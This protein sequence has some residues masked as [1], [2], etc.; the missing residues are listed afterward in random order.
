MA[1]QDSEWQNLSIP[2]Q[3]NHKLWKAR[4]AAYESLIKQFQLAEDE[5][6]PVFKDWNYNHQW[7][8]KAVTDSNAVAHEKGVQLVSIYVRLAGRAGSKCRS[9][10]LTPLV[11]KSLALNARK[12]TREAA[13]ECILGWTVFE[14]D[15]D[16]AENI[17]SAVLEG[18]NSKQPKVVAG[19]VSGLNALVSAF[20]VKVLNIKPILKSLSTIFAHPDK[21][22]RAEGTLLVQTLY[23]FLGPA[24]EPSLTDLKPVQVKELHDTFATMD[25]EGKGKGTGLPTRETAAQKQRR[26]EKE[27]QAALQDEQPQDESGQDDAA[28]NADPP[29][30]LPEDIDPYDLADPVAVLDQLPSGFFEHL[31]SSKWKER[32]EE[33]L[34]PLLA[35]LKP[36][37]KIKPDHYDELVKALAGRMADANILCVIGAANCLECLAKGLR[38]QF[39]KYRSLMVV[40]MLEKFKERKANVVEALSNCLDAMALTVELG[41]L[42]EDIV[43]F[44]KHKNP[45]V[46][47]QTMKF[48]VRCL[49]N[50]VHAIP[51]AEVKSLSDVLLSGLE[52]AVVPVREISAEGLGTL[53]K[54]VGKASFLPI[55]QGQDDLRKVKV[56]EYYEKAEVKYQPPKA[57]PKSQP[58]KPIFKAPPTK[59]K[60]AQKPPTRVD[61]LASPTSIDDFSSSAAS[62]P[63]VVKAAP[64]PVKKVPPAAAAPL[65]IKKTVTAV[66]SGKSSGKVIE[67]IR[68][69][70]SQEEAEARAPDCL[71]ASFIEG[72]GNSLWK[73]R[74]AALEELLAWIPEHADEIEAEV[75][76]RY[77]NKKPG[78]KESNFQVWQRVFAVF[79]LLAEQ[80]PSFTKACMAL[81][82]PSCMEK[83]GDAKIKEAAGNALLTFAEKTSLGFVL[84]HAFDPI[85]KQKA[86]KI[87]AESFLFIDSAL[88]DFGIV[89]VPVRDL[90]ECLKTGLKSV[91]AAVRT[92]ATKALVTT[93][94]CLGADIS[95][96]LQDLNPQLLSTIEGEFAKNAAERPPEP[97]R[98]SAD[99][100]HT[101]SDVANGP[102]GK[103]K[104]LGGGDPLDDLF[105]RVDLDRLVAS[106]TVKACDD[107]AWKVRKEALES[108]QGILEQN[109]RLKPNLGS[110]LLS[111]LKLRL[112]DVNKVVQGLALDVISRIATG[113][114]K[115]FER[116]AKTLASAI[117]S[118]LADKNVGARNNALTTLSN[119]ADSCGLDCLIS[120]VGSSLEVAKPELRSS[121]LNWIVQRFSDLE[122]IKG[123]DLTS[124]ASP[125]VSCLEDRNGEVRKGAMALLPTII[126]SVGIDLILDQTISLK[127]ASRNNLV[128]I[129]ESFRA[130]ASSKPIPSKALPSKTGTKSASLANKPPPRAPSVAS[131]H[132]PSTPS[133][134]ERS[135]LS[136]SKL[137]GLRKPIASKLG[138]APNI[139]TSPA[140][141]AAPTSELPFRSGDP[142][143]KAAR[144]SKETGPLKWVIEGAVRKDQIEQLYMQ[145]APQISSELLGQ[146]FSKDH[147]CEKDFLA[148]LNAIEAWTSDPSSAS[149]EADLEES[150]IRDRLLANSDLVFK[151]LTIRLHDTNTTITMKCLDIIEQYIVALQLDEYRLT[152]YEAS[153]LLPSLIGRCGDSKEVLRTRIRM[154]FKNICGIYPFS[155]VFQSLVDNGLKSKNA[156][157]RAE[158][159]EELS[160]LFQRH[161]LSVCQPAKALPLIASLISDRDSSVRNGALS[162]LASAYASAGDVIL[163]YVGN[164]SG[165]EHDMLTERLKRTEAPASPK[166]NRPTSEVSQRLPGVP[167]M[168]IKAVQRPSS[169]LSHSNDGET[170]GSGKPGIRR[171]SLASKLNSPPSILPSKMPAPSA[172]AP[173][174]RLSKVD[175]SRTSTLLS[176]SAKLPPPQSP[177]RLSVNQAPLIHSTHL[178][179]IVNHSIPIEEILSSDDIRSTEALKAVQADIAQNPDALISSAD[180]LIDVIA[181]QMKIAFENLSETTPPTTLRL[182]KHLMQT[183]STFFDRSQLG[184]VVGKDSLV[185]IL[186]QLTQRL[187]ET[188]DNPIN[189]HITSLSKVLNMVLIR[190]FHNANRTACFGALFTVLKMTTI[191]LREIEDEVELGHRAKYAELVMK[192]LWKVSKTVKE[193]LEDG[194]LDVSILLRDIDEFLVSIP[195]AEWRRRASD[196]VPLADMPL[197]TVK[198]ILQQVV[199]IYGDGVYEAVSALKNPQDTF[200]YQYLFRLLNHSRSSTEKLPLSQPLQATQNGQAI[201][202]SA[203]SL[204]HLSRPPLTTTLSSASAKADPKSTVSLLT[205]TTASKTL[206][207]TEPLAEADLNN[208]LT[209]V[210]AKIGSPTDSKK[211]IAELYHLLKTHPEANAKV[212]KWIGATGTYFQAYLRRALNNLKADDPDYQQVNENIQSNQ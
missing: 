86:V 49:R 52:D 137:G 40:P 174:P 171:P 22:V 71:E 136:K 36:A 78:P 126:Q 82:I 139:P 111:S 41:D 140:S 106:S 143:A 46:K 47:E 11:E 172:A 35:T 200:V 109:K 59:S 83:Y 37:I 70:M 162:A 199:T 206:K 182:C 73:T 122:A 90:I 186:A 142:K 149:E 175:Y 69:K 178:N 39:A 24:L 15:N 65:A 89:G 204:E 56:E 127:P 57:K 198:T 141:A 32:K 209:E 27:A 1:E 34:D 94:I 203:T 100:S 6:D 105:P 18:L 31:A 28:A 48:L 191:D 196:N 148:G 72:V 74:L 190:I 80:C 96:F 63:P 184:T 110:D 92:N 67:E 120:S 115:P 211:G 163:K 180:A 151:Y 155:K 26:L 202:T 201:L 61:S 193:S 9:D 77:L 101:A 12:G 123:L 145:M 124:F 23:S 107:P 102:K 135:A 43:N 62:K 4:L 116:Y 3:L 194:T 17:I 212:D 16:K 152:D 177:L 64:K 121:A 159:A 76:V 153:A 13:I 130:S 181:T 98:F 104:G 160:A 134:D 170:N 188:A 195:P 42:T 208:H 95:T 2:D 45:Q 60:S 91:N 14:A 173:G 125:I 146:L 87:Q 205:G 88:I 161:G 20:G 119:I 29:A 75:I 210:F 117:L 167:R 10:C 112:A 103:V 192:C 187:Q 38:S 8:V 54:L 176:S 51:K 132:R 55:I 144:A 99:I 207:T 131:I 97:I 118:I 7:P 138:G 133:H 183:L 84:S 53:M 164:L 156:R 147:H 68:F 21:G 197:R 58:P 25:A 158:C 150:D 44:S 128:P 114:G 166:P 129:I 81:S 50:T 19:S 5:D 66:P 113:M 33:A 85:S 108:I 154:I 79:Q 189:E 165:K 185:S 169:A 93:K 30:D 179:N 168:N 157:V